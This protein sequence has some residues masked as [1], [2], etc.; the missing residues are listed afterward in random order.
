MKLL[1]FIPLFAAGWVVA[2]EPDLSKRTAPAAEI[3]EGPRSMSALAARRGT[4]TDAVRAGAA[5]A[6]LSDSTVV[7]PGVCG[8]DPWAGPCAE[9]GGGGGGGFDDEL[10]P[11]ESEKHCGLPPDHPYNS[12]PTWTQMHGG[13]M[14]NEPGEVARFVPCEMV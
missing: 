1:L 9:D 4:A 8:V 7:L 13:W 11:M 5:A 3:R 2:A 12:N 6:S 14:V 10:P